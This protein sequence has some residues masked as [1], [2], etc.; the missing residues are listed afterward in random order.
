MNPLGLYFE[1]TIRGVLGDKDVLH[2]D[3]A[4]GDVVI[5]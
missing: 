2:R 4:V 5:M 1:M 3:V